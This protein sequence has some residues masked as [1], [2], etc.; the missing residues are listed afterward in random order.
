MDK[1]QSSDLHSL[2]R[3]SLFRKQVRGLPLSY[4]EDYGRGLP[5]EALSD[6]DL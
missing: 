1:D 4:T 3:K 5:Q 6:S 2:F